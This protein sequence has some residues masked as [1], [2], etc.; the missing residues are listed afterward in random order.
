MVYKGVLGNKNV[1]VKK[2][3]VNKD[4]VSEK[5]F[6]R[7]VASLMKIEKHQNLVRFLG[8]C[9][10]KARVVEEQTG[11]EE[12]IYFQIMDILLCFE[13]ISNGSLDKHITDELRGLTWDT[14]F[15]IIRGICEG[16]R[17]LHED[18]SIIH[19]DL[20]PANI[21]LDDHMIPKITD[22]GQSRF[23]ENTH[24]KEI[25]ITPKY[26]APEYLKDGRTSK[27]ADIYSLG[28]VIR[29]LVTG[30]EDSRDTAHVLRRWT[31]RWHKQQT[32]HQYQQV[33]KCMEIAVRCSEHE[34]ENRPSISDIIRGL[35]EI[36]S[37]NGPID[38]MSLYQYDDMLGIEPL[39]LCFSLEH[40]SCLVE[41]TNET[42]N[43]IAFNIGRPSKQYSTQPDKGIVPPGCKRDV[44]ITLQPHE[45]ATQ[46]T[47]SDKLVV[48]STQVSVGVADH[49]ITSDMFIT[50]GG[51]NV[52]DK[53]SL[54][55][56]YQPKTI[57]LQEEAVP[58]DIGS[59]SRNKKIRRLSTPQLLYF[60]LV[61]S[62][63][64]NLAT[65]L[66]SDQTVDLAT[67][68]IG[69][70]LAKLSEL[71]NMY[72]LEASIRSDVDCVIH[73]L[74]VM[75][76][77]LCN[78]SE[79]QWDS[80]N[81][82]IKLA[83]LWAGEVRELSYNIEDVV[84]GFLIHA[85]GSEPA[86]R[87]GG[88]IESIKR[89]MGLFMSGSSTSHQIGGAIK[90][91]KNKVQHQS[92]WKG[93]YK[94]EEVKKVANTV[95]TINAHYLSALVKDRDK[96][97]GIDDAINDLT[98]RLRG[99]DGNGDMYGLKI[100]SI[101]GIGGLGK[102]TLA[103]AVYN[104]LKGSFRLT[105]FVSLGRNPDV[106]KLFYDILFELD[107]PRHTKLK[108][109]NLDESQ[110]IRVLTDLLKN[111]RY[112]IV[113]DDMWDTKVWHD[114]I[115]FAFLGSKCG[116]K[117]IITTRIFEVAAIA[118][119]VY[120]LNPLSDGY[121]EELFYATLSPEEGCEYDLTDGVIEKILSKCDGVPLA[122]ITIASMLGSKQRED[123]PKVYN[124][125]GFGTEVT[126]DVDNT[127][128]ILLFSYSDLPRH[129]R[130]CLL[131]L[132]IYPENYFICKDTVI[133]MWVAEGFVHDESG[134]SL[135]EIGERYFNQLVNRSMVQLVAN[136][137]YL[138]STMIH[139]RIHDLVLDMICALSKD[140]NFVT[141]LEIDEQH[142]SLKNNARRLAVQK[143]DIEKLDP[144]TINC[145]GL[146]SFYAI[147]CHIDVMQPL[148]RFKVLRVL[149]LAGCRI[150][151]DQPYQL[152]HIGNLL[153]L[154]YL[155][156]E[157]MPICKLPEEIGDL[158][159]LQTLVLKGT[160]I[161]ELPHSVGLLRQLKCLCAPK[162]K[163]PDWL[164]NMT[165]LEDLKLDALMPFVFAEGLINL[166]ELRDLQIQSYRSFGDNSDRALV[167]SIGN[168]H[169]LQSLILINFMDNA[170][171]IWEGFVPPRHLH[172]MNMYVG[173]Y[174]VPPWMDPTHL[175][176][177]SV[178]QL[179]LCSM[180]ARCLEILGRLP[181]LHTLK[182]QTG[183]G[184]W[185][186]VTGSGAFPKLR[187]LRS[188]R[189]MLRFQRG[190][191]T[192][193]EYLELEVRVPELKKAKFDCDF[194]SLGNLPLLQKLSVHLTCK[195]DDPEYGKR[196]EVA[197]KHAID[198]HPH[199][200]PI[201][202]WIH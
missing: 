173:F 39:E 70:L 125:I 81:E 51:K 60:D 141:L 150:N 82:N 185:L 101:F 196:M 36:E 151:E 55:V 49:N 25:F 191:M 9:S 186:T 99:A 3:S 174:G 72:N 10:N 15:D 11:S 200:R 84:D 74:R 31:H 116:S 54:M 156:L 1:A 169:K 47:S 123:W 171:E 78:V 42:T 90:D 104:Q 40:I 147:G 119:D 26:G 73:E 85:K 142:T 67:G 5:L 163:V 32:Q 199:R 20:K 41:L 88:L 16:M 63:P 27:K 143:R 75:R 195:A 91:I 68:A 161:K 50:K 2:I 102:T 193:L 109:A 103:R 107:E 46:V 136:P 113:I 129:I 35:S 108:P 127:R 69:S 188:S 192:R 145:H 165:S 43:S 95:S 194:T 166:K 187:H 14:R 144:P 83:K 56:L 21:L 159:F 181:E 28:V 93:K 158:L 114:F 29:E 64:R 77:D 146:R 167:K 118:T 124:S 131:H 112:L 8:F 153:Q 178:L 71:L 198:R 89:I 59:S 106:K 110:L 19:M 24:T 140:E 179:H 190:V 92:S 132:S 202:H 23:A 183:E 57:N 13:Y 162:V 149:S 76:A 37:T 157:R 154:R 120:K 182:L 6:H 98:K 121:S 175:P 201:L 111:N 155:G 12:P 122:I 137:R 44:K 80:N 130:T 33:I 86:T 135:F 53:V 4:T 100:H 17:Y 61:E 79:V 45:S 66:M 168:L 170:D 148:S 96:L 176:S 48:K 117:I 180:E 177:L 139:F 34:P 87:I 133:W 128:K 164:V 58:E 172:S 126:E 65:G 30:S 52:V 152:E 18:K 189:A 134:R 38:Q 160:K 62:I 115:K 7:E 97:F 105:A 94:V 22:F 184:S 197:V 138:V